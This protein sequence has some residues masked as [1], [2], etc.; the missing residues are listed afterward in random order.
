MTMAGD[1]NV[2]WIHGAPDC[3]QTT[4]PPLQ[5]H[6]YDADT[7]ILR[8]SK[9]SEP[10]TPADPGPS[11]EAP[12]LYLLVGKTRA[13]LLDTGASSS[14]TIFPL[15]VTVRRLLAEHASAAGTSPVPLVAAH[16][17]SHGDH[18]AG[19]GQFHG[20]ADTTVVPLGVAGVRAFFGLPQWP[21]GRAEFDLGGRV[22]DVLPIPGHEPS[23]VAL[24]DRATGLLLTGDTLYPGLLVVNDW[25]AYVASAARLKTFA[26]THPVTFV[27]G[28]HVEMTNQPGHWF[29]LG[30][31]FQPGEHV[32]QLG[33]Q[34]LDEWAAAVQRLANHPQTDRHGDFIIWPSD[35]PMPALHP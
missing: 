5:V 6:R 9:C 31:L 25:A 4:D 20:A 34:H 16:T 7:F 21:E 29:G 10:G 18:C 17:H 24:Y 22:L 11:F 32:L 14:P 23:H 13:L 26:A 35:R 15:A 27:L 8:Q 2:T 3:S 19:D 12:F 1:L 28:G 30:T 33:P